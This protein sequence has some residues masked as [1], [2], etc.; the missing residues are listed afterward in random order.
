MARKN[1]VLHALAGLGDPTPHITARSMLTRLLQ[2]WDACVPPYGLNC[3]AS[4]IMP[5]LCVS[6]P[7]L[8][9]RAVTPLYVYAGLVICAEMTCGALSFFSDGPRLDK[10]WWPS[11]N[12]R[13]QGPCWPSSAT[14]SS[15][16]E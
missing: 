2:R 7:R 13:S 8:A 9:R 12:E 6:P 4:L 14:A 1:P 15:Q 10:W 5:P 11:R 3:F 16:S